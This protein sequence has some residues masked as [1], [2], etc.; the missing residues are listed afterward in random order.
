[1]LSTFNDDILDAMATKNILLHLHHHGIPVSYYD[2]YPS[3]SKFFRILSTNMIDGQEIVTTTEAIN[4]PIYTV[5][6]HP[7]AVLEPA[8]D[9]HAVRTTL[10][11]RLA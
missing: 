2:V 8:S 4:Y 3:L 5:Q 1:M 9:I 11:F 7:E 6:Y 10:T